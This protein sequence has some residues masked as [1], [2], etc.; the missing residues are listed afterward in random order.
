MAKP[1]PFFE[2]SP[3]AAQDMLNRLGDAMAAYLAAQAEA[4]AQVL[5]LFR[6]LGRATRSF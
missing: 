3:E 6:F 1:E 2:P 5:M 4:G